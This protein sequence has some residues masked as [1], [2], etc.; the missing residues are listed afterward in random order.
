MASTA[1][2]IS[3]YHVISRYISPYLPIS[4]YLATSARTAERI[5]P[6]LAI[7]RSIP[8]HRGAH[9]RDG[10]CEDGLLEVALLLL[11]L[12]VPRQAQ[13]RGLGLGSR[14]GLGVRVRCAGAGAGWSAS[15]FGQGS[16]AS[17]H[18]RS[19]GLRS[20]S[21]R[22]HYNISL[23]LPITSP[24][25]ISL[26]LARSRYISLY[27][28]IAPQASHVEHGVAQHEPAAHPLLVQL[29]LGQVEPALRREMPGD[30]GRCREMPGGVGRCGEAWGGE[31]K[32]VG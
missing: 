24:Y 15:V 20:T 13:A 19:T 21:P 17:A 32:S 1:E 14:L 30:V 22:A 16:S 6:Y 26:D 3:L 23:D 11:P 31:R 18:M 10:E 28:A 2:R 8:A 29:V 7:S 25:N 9:L 5:S 12:G 4:L 27:L